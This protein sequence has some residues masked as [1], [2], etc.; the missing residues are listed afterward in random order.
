MRANY[1]IQR[2][3]LD[4]DLEE[5]AVIKLDKA[6]VNY[7]GNVLRMRTGDPLLV[8][9]GRDGEWEALLLVEMKRLDDP[10]RLW[11]QPQK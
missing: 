2:L 9:N 4:V 6:Q 8:F 11:D 10:H 5:D 7:V 3:F 1:K